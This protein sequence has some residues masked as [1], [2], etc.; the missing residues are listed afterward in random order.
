MF[1]TFALRILFY[2]KCQLC[3]NFPLYSEMDLSSALVQ[4]AH[5]TPTNSS[6]QSS[7]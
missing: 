7:M 1:V 2:T 6:N 5:I 4:A 3:G